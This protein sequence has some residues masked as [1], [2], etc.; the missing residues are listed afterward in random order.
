MENILSSA[1]QSRAERIYVHVA[2][3]R[4]GCSKRTIR[5]LIKDG[6]LRAERHGRRAWL[7]LRCDVDS[8]CN[9]RG[10]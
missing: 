8:F 1:G 5:R 2:A 9:E 10:E 3:N 6:K 4:I 7:I